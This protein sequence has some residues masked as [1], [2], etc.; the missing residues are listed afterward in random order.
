MDKKIITAYG[1]IPIPNEFVKQNYSWLSK[2]IDNAEPCDNYGDMQIFKN[3]KKLEPVYK[4]LSQDEIKKLFDV[5]E[6]ESIKKAHIHNILMACVFSV[7]ST[8]MAAEGSQITFMDGFVNKYKR[9][10]NKK[11][12]VVINYLAGNGIVRWLKE[13]YNLIPVTDGNYIWSCDRVI[14]DAY[15]PFYLIQSECKVVF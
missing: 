15:I 4:K 13:F 7:G 12:E 5:A 3:G 14:P 10:P 8:T 11:D 1:E 6:I 2:W 9:L